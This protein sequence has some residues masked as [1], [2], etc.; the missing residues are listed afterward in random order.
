MKEGRFVEKV[1]SHQVISKR[2]KD[3]IEGPSPKKS[4]RLSKIKEKLADV[5]TNKERSPTERHRRSVKKIS[6]KSV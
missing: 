3:A 2:K 4:P 5:F 6:T 1:E